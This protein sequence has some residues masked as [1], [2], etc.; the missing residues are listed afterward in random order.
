MASLRYVS[1]LGTVVSAIDNSPVPVIALISGVA[2][3]GGKKLITGIFIYIWVS[4]AGLS[5]LAGHAL[6]KGTSRY[7][8]DLP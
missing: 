8:Y 2:H 7:I 3:G 1:Q 6:S 4:G 5:S